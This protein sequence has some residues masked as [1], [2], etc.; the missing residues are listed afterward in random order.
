LLCVFLAD[1]HYAR[2]AYI[3][4]RHADPIK[5][6]SESFIDAQILP[7]RE[8][9]IPIILLRHHPEPRA[10]PRTLNVRVHPKHLQLTG[11]ARGHEGNH[12]HGGGLPST[13]GTQEA[14]RLGEPD[15]DVDS[16]HRLDRA[17]PLA[18]SA[19]VHESAVV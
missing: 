19:G 13:V 2:R 3:L 4:R 10:D 17:E 14:E 6:V 7:H 9:V 5:R 18:Q 8:P 11:A 1:P 12:A 16:A 15:V